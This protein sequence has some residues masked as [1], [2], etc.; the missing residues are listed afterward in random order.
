MPKKFDIENHIFEIKPKKKLSIKDLAKLSGELLTECL[1]RDKPL[2]ELYIVNNLVGGQSA[3]IAK[4]HH[5]MADGI[6]GVDLIKILFDISPEPS[7]VPPK[8]AF[9][10]PKKRNRSDPTIF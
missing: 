2:W 6:S 5:C 8:P 4:V 9:E 7:P 3:L 10:P 1:N